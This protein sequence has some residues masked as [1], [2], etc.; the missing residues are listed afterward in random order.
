MA[1]ITIL[2]IL[3][4]IYKLR[5]DFRVTKFLKLFKKNVSQLKDIDNE[6]GEKQMLDWLN[7]VVEKEKQISFRTLSQNDFVTSLL[8][9]FLYKNE[10]MQNSVF[11]LLH[12]TFNQNSILMDS[13][14]DT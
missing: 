6:E 11:L 10:D 1:K 3:D 14:L 5:N 13:L 12:K 4:L 8:D 2:N 9:L 7:I